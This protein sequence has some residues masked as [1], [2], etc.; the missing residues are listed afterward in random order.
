MANFT[1][2]HTMINAWFKSLSVCT[3]AMAA[4]RLALQYD[5]SSH[6]IRY[7]T[8]TFWL[9]VEAAVAIIM[10]SISSYRVV[11]L[12]YLAERKMQHSLRSG[13]PKPYRPWGQTISQE[14]SDISR[15]TAAPTEAELGYSLSE[16]P[17]LGGQ[18]R[19]DYSTP[20]D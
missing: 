9:V 17:V 5:G 15:S 7:V 18:V 1:R 14:R 6:H 4:T 2:S 19:K 3:I 10:A 11:L 12:D 16:L 8:L 20:V 13:R